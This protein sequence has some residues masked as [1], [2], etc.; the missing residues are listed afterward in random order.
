MSVKK[1]V[2][3]AGLHK[4]GTSS[5]QDSLFWGNHIL[6][7]YGYC[8]ITAWGRNHGHILYNL[9]SEKPANEFYWN[10]IYGYDDAAVAQFNE[11]NLALLRETAEKEHPEVL[12]VSGEMMEL[13]SVQELERMAAFFARQFVGAQVQLLL[14]IRHPQN[15]LVS[16]TQQLEAFPLFPQGAPQNDALGDYWSYENRVGK[17]I[18]AF[19]ERLEIVHFEEAVKE[20][21]GLVPHFLYTIGYPREAKMI[22]LIFANESRCDEAVEFMQYINRHAP[23]LLQTDRGWEKHPDRS[24]GDVTPLFLVKGARYIFPAEK[25]DRLDQVVRR[26]IAW[27]EQ[28]LGISYRPLPDVPQA[29]AGEIYSD[30]TLQDFIRI[31]P[32]LTMCMKSLFLDFFR[33]QHRRTGDD[34]F[35]A[36]FETGSA[37]WQTFCF[38]SSFYKSLQKTPDLIHDNQIHF[39]GIS[40]ATGLDKL[41]IFWNA[42]NGFLEEDSFNV[43]KKG[44]QYSVSL[45]FDE[46]R[47]LQNF[48]IDPSGFPCVA[49]ITRLLINGKEGVAECIGGNYIQ[50]LDNLYYFWADDPQICFFSPEVITSIDLEL[51]VE[52]GSYAYSF[53]N[54]IML[55]TRTEREAAFQG[56]QY[57]V[58]EMESAHSK[59]TE[60]F[61]WL[62]G[63]HERLQAMHTELTR[64]NRTLAADFEWLRGEHE[65]LQAAHTELTRQNQKLAADFEWLRGEHA[66]LKKEHE[67]FLNSVSWKITKPI[68]AV[69]NIFQKD[70]Q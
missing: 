50:T 45:A 44:N 48:R 12:I 21:D 15:M 16:W 27:L 10:A 55:K 2:I 62:Y 23:I 51:L 42:G 19:G 41:Q 13:L 43:E 57:K 46:D 40:Q 28:N 5:I 8:Y 61:T 9:F 3:H 39:D 29:A 66:A 30:G 47:M 4:T 56:L 65:R 67:D 18:K 22:D 37:P 26:E 32:T 58:E 20:K 24:L 69:G 59:L 17:F 11:K 53:C 60:E 70:G 49:L 63:E 1:I 38:T 64:Q 31:F 33:E 68:R 34:R 6:K 52:P 35:L 36:L 7:K 54:K 25:K 14:Y